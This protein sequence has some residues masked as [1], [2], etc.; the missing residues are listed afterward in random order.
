MVVYV[1][2]E[3]ENLFIFKRRFGKD[4]PIKTFSDPHEALSFIKVSAAMNFPV[5]V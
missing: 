5:A 2:D 4:F 1:D 3:E